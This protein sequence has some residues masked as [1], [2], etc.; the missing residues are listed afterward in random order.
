MKQRE[1]ITEEFIELMK[2]PELKALME[3]ALAQA[4]EQNP[5]H[6]SNPAFNLEELYDFIDWSCRCMPWDCIDASCMTE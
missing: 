3:K 4:R 5:D 2:D 6:I 1:K